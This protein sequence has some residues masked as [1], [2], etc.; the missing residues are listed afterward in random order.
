MEKTIKLHPKQAEA[1]ES[2]KRY[3]AVICGKQSGKT[4]LGSVW[5]LKKINDFP[6]KNGL[7]ASPTYK[8]L[9]QSTLDKFF[10]LFPEFRKF[11][12]Q[13]QGIIE[14][15]TGGKVY[16]RSTDEPLGLEGMTLKWAWLDEA[17]MMNRLVWVIIRART[18][19]EN[20]QVLITT[21]PYTLNWLY[22]E[23]YIPWKEGKDKDLAVYSWRSIDNP[24]FPKE[25]YEKEKER[26]SEKEFARQ[27]L[28]QFTKMEGLVYELQPHQIIQEKKLKTQKQLSE[29]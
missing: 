17:G 19:I 14:L 21:N 20:G 7:I 16:I 18:A 23:F 24:Y 1:F 22:D 9:N 4:F 15:P 11:Y 25:F 26:L 3:T 10:S 6:E 5:A 2:D 12:K 29:E 13:Q 27:Y 8:L 28:G